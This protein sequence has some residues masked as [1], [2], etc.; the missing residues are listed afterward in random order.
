MISTPRAHAPAR[1]SSRDAPA[2]SFSHHLVAE[3]D[4]CEELLRFVNPPR[5]ILQC[6]N[7]V[8]I[9]VSQREPVVR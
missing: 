4:A 1:F 3:A 7:P 8:N 2:Q 6:V 9:V 5:E